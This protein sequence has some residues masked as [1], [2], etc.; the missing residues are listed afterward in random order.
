MIEVQNCSISS[1][2]TNLVA[3]MTMACYNIVSTAPIGSATGLKPSLV[4]YGD[5]MAAVIG[6]S[7][8]LEKS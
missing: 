1:R 3:E 2:V 5:R 6:L 8:L 7:T 4:T